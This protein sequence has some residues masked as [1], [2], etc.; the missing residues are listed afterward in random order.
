MSKFHNTSLKKIFFRLRFLLVIPLFAI[1]LFLVKSEFFLIDEVRCKTQYGPCSPGDEN[2]ASNMKDKN[3]FLLSASETIE[4]LKQSFIN[5]SVL[6]QK[7]F[8]K[9][10]EIFIEKRKPVVAL[11]QEEVGNRG[12][13]LIDKDGV[14]VGFTKDSQLPLIVVEYKEEDLSVGGTVREK[15]KKAA[16]IL[17]L[18]YN[19]QSATQVQ[20]KEDFLIADLPEGSQVYFPLDKEPQSL[21]GALQLIIARSRIEG[22]LPKSIDLRYSNPVLKY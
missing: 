12:F 21:V 17:Y 20:L 2:I 11:M 4:D 15:I 22:N 3:L 14:V 16:D 13:F 18:L 19:A 7:V 5:K 6:V 9:T 10:V 1:P 8:P